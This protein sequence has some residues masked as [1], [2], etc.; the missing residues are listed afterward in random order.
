MFIVR[1]Y[2][3]K[4]I[5]CIAFFHGTTLHVDNVSPEKANF[6]KLSSKAQKII[7]QAME[8]ISTAMDSL[9]EGSIQLSQLKFLLENEE[10]FL[11]VTECTVAHKSNTAA[12]LTLRKHELEA[13]ETNS[14]HVEKLF[15]YCQE[16]LKTGR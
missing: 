9:C 2:M 16:Y 4:T 11:S 7:T 13:Y 14:S 12:L 10:R 3:T 5:P 8:S 1:L 15:E 6:A